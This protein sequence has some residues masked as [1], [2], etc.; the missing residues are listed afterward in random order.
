MLTSFVDPGAEVKQHKLLSIHCICFA[1]W[2]HVHPPFF[3]AGCGSYLIDISRDADVPHSGVI[4]E[5]DFEPISTIIPIC[6]LV[7]SPLGVSQGL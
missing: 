6:F 7:Q 5:L 4:A 3:P 1:T 2:F